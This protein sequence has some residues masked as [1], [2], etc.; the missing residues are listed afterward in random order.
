MSHNSNALTVNPDAIDDAILDFRSIIDSV[1]SPTDAELK[2]KLEDVYARVFYSVYYV[3]NNNDDDDKNNKSGDGE[4]DQQLTAYAVLLRERE[5]LWLREKNRLTEEVETLKK[6]KRMENSN[7]G[8]SSSTSTDAK[9]DE[10][11]RRLQKLL[12][13][14]E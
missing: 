6:K 1:S 4:D 5:G 12:Q 9:L 14:L 11:K 2:K 10:T 8:S 3:N 7:G 13:E